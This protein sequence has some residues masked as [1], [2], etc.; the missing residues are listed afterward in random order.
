[1]IKSYYYYFTTINLTQ[2]VF[3]P[4]FTPLGVE[5]QNVL[6]YLTPTS[7]ELYTTKMS[8]IKVQWFGPGIDERVYRPFYFIYIRVYIVINQYYFLYNFLCIDK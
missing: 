8:C 4:Y 3:N 2:P 1:M 6:S 7:L 5:F